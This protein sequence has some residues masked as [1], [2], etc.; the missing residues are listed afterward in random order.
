M[1]LETDGLLVA[2]KQVSSCHCAYVAAAGWHSCLGEYQNMAGW[3]VPAELDQPF[4]RI[5]K[6]R[7]VFVI[8]VVSQVAGFVFFIALIGGTYGMDL[9]KAQVLKERGVLAAGTV[10]NLYT[11]NGGKGRTNYNVTYAYP[12]VPKPVYT[13]T[14]Q[15]DVQNFS[16]LHVGDVVPV[17]Y[18][19]SYPRRSLLNFN[20]IVF[21]RDNTQSLILG[22]AILSFVLL[23]TLFVELIFI[24]NYRRQKRLLQWGKAAAATIVSDIEYS[25]GR[26]GR[27]A[28]V[29]YTFTDESGHVVEGKRK[30]LPIQKQRKGDMYDKMFA[31]PTVLYDPEDSSKNMLYPFALVDCPPKSQ[32]SIFSA[33]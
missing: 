16:Q 2:P 20:D 32:P 27:K 8:L 18:D 22:C 4:P 7:S 25:D 14:D 3:I 24:R 23:S 11:S 33:A 10:T 21:E 17:A 1:R 15:L 19:P 30:G 29:T 28:A 6:R 13:A 26:A 5:A 12:V 9:Y 31:D